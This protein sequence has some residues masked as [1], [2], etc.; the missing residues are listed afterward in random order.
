MQTFPVSISSLL[1]ELI[2]DWGIE[3]RVDYG[4]V[5]DQWTQIVGDPV[6]QKAKIDKIENGKIFLK[7]ESTAWR[8]ELFF[9]KKELIQKVNLFLG[10]EAI[11][12][13]LFF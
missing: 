4:T 6:S 1:R 8:Q 11:K 7:V 2:S 3:R 10:K 5:I 13:I 9:Q 12:E